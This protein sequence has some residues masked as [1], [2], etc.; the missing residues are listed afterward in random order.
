MKGK[1][2]KE[3]TGWPLEPGE[4]KVKNPEAHVAVCTLEDD[5]LLNVEGVALYGKNCTENLGLER[6]IVNVISNQNIRFLIICGKEIR[7]HRSGQSLIALWRNGLNE[8]NR[9]IGAEGALPYI[10]NIPASFVERFRRQ[11]EVIDLIGVTE[12]RIVADEVRR[13]LSGGGRIEPYCGGEL[14]FSTYLAGEDVPE[15]GLNLKTGVVIVSPEYDIVFDPRRG[16][17]RQDR[18]AC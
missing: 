2:H 15:F 8:K 4:Y 13:I 5:M 17:V 10:Q 3:H 7:G 14:D 18:R 11:V 1:T 6:I 16:V 9:I 12:K